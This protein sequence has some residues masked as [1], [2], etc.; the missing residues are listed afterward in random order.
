[1]GLAIES[2]IGAGAGDKDDNRTV[3]ADTAAQ[4]A[5]ARMFR[6][7]KAGR[8]WLRAQQDAAAKAL[9][10]GC[11]LM[12]PGNDEPPLF[13]IPG[14]PGS[15]FQLVP[16]AAAL[17][18]AMPVYAI[19]PRGLDDGGQTPCATIAEMAEHAIGI[20]RAA[21]PEG[22][23]L[24]VGYSAGGLVA[25]EM[26]Q[27]LTRAGHDVPALLFLDTYPGKPNWPFRCHA[28]VLARQ[29]LGA[30]R[31]LR[32]CGPRQV[33]GELVRR[34]CSLI[35]Y[36]AASG[37]GMLRPPEVVA[38]GWSD[39]SRRVYLATYNAGESYRPAPY[40]GKVVIVR[41]TELE[42]LMPSSPA[43]AWRSFLADMETRQIPGS[44]L[45]MV[46]QNAAATAAAMG[47]SLQRLMQRGKARR[48]ADDTAKPLPAPAPAGATLEP[49]LG[50]S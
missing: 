21:R 20:L 2:T 38:E 42:D 29:T 41:P 7:V 48:S 4:T 25:L 39:E 12:K 43:R 3:P 15:V 17:P 22:P 26:A 47:D 37:V 32:K 18:L 44:H 9:P 45:G 34:G 28:E 40:A 10:P 27:R 1:M 8:S 5:T 30:L 46:E 36:L 24:L 50:C 13:M 49:S 6:S 23:Y 19:K 31:A 33:F 16:V 11:V 35:D 14:A